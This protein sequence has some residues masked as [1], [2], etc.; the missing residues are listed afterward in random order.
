MSKVDKK[1]TASP[2]PRR[3][4]SEFERGGIIWLSIAE[5]NPTDI[6]RYMSIPRTTI[7][8]TIQ[9][10]KN[11]GTT[12][13]KPRPGRPKKLSVTDERSLSLSV[14]RNPT[15]TYAYHQASLAAA[16]VSIS[17]HTVIKYIKENNHKTKIAGIKHQKK[18]HKKKEKAKAVKT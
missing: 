6:S 16:G 2:P 3:E 14:K 5:H 13:T 1:D 8:D 7:C 10:W 9:R 18:E 15:E 4:L 12:N 17:K 11:D